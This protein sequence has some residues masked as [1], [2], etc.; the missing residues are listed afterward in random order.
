MAVAHTTWPYYVALN[1]IQKMMIGIGAFQDHGIV[2]GE[3]DEAKTLTART[4]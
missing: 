4:H 2:M 3:Y 1:H